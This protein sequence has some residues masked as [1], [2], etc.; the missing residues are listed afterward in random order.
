MRHVQHDAQRGDRAHQVGRQSS[1][2]SGQTNRDATTIYHRHNS[3][4]RYGG[5]HH[6]PTATTAAATTTVVSTTR[7]TV[8]DVVDQHHDV[9]RLQRQSTTNDVQR[10]ATTVSVALQIALPST[11]ILI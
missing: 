7:N 2:S 6:G 5:S 9:E 8:I 10:T 1:Y 4:Q 11:T 3:G